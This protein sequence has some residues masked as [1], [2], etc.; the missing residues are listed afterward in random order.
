MVYTELAP[1][2]QQFHVAPAM[3]QQDSCQYTAS[4]DIK[5]MRYEKDSAFFSFFLQ[6]PE[7]SGSALEHRLALYVKEI[8]NN[9]NNNELLCDA[10]SPH[11]HHTLSLHTGTA[12]NSQQSVE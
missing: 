12:L 2:R 4:M 7:R 9:S 6:R 8:N 1:R 5:N 10:T 3:Q 11:P